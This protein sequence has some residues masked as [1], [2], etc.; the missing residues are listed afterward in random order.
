MDNKFG[1]EQNEGDEDIT[2]EKVTSVIISKG[3]AQCVR[4]AR[5]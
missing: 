2:K 5:K 3:G 1:V 4:V